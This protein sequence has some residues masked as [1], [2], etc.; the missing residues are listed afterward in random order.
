MTIDINKPKNIIHTEYGDLI[1]DPLFNNKLYLHGLEL[2]NGSKSGKKFACAYNLLHVQSGRDRDTMSSATIEAQKIAQIWRTAI[3][4]KSG[5][6]GWALCRMYFS[7]LYKN[8]CADVHQSAD[9][10]EKDLATSVWKSRL[11][12]Y[13]DRDMFY[14]CDNDTTE[15]SRCG[16]MISHLKALTKIGLKHH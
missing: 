9:F 10:I 7:L 1:L 5:S 12:G 2:P 3:L 14:H 6:G 4:E 8:I 15:V 16:Y 13:R 11:L